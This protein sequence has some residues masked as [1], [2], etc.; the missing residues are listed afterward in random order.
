MAANDKTRWERETE[1]TCGD[2]AV[3]LD[4]TRRRLEMRRRSGEPCPDAEIALSEA[5]RQLVAG[6]ENLIKAV[7]FETERK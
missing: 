3:L 1:E 2:V 7:R 5:E 6:M 4:Y